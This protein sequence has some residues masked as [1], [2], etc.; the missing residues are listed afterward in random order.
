MKKIC[1][2]SVA[3]YIPDSIRNEPRNIGLL[4]LNED[5]SFYNSKFLKI[6]HSKLTGATEHA[7]REII[8]HF[9]EYY[10]NESFKTKDDIVKATTNGSFGKIQFTDIKAV[11]TEDFDTEFHYLFNL[12]VQEKE[13]HIV[14]HTR[15]KMLKTSIKEE[16]KHENLLGANKIKPNEIVKAQKSKFEYTVDFYLKANGKTFL[17]DAVDLTVG[18][19]ND[20]FETA[21]K[22]R[23]LK[24]SK[25][26]FETISL[27]RKSSNVD[28]S[29]FLRVL[30]ATSTVYDY[31]NGGREV[32]L[33]RFRKIIL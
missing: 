24:T 3:K 16:L 12:Y 19:K 32:F 11:V 22:F 21:Y 20:S 2:Y 4:F 28:V 25:N 10:K 1:Y 30:N 6:S 14:R 33:K 8:K 31:S 9:S 29:K 13:K 26:K 18:D 23:D 17:M 15:G 7:D 27:I 5:D